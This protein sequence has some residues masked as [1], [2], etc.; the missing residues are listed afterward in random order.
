[1]AV[2][3]TEISPEV[4][5]EIAGLAGHQLADPAVAADCQALLERHGVVVY[6]ETHVGDDDLVAFSRLLGQVVVAPVG[7][8]DTHPE[9]SKITLDPAESVLAAYRRGTFFWHIDGANDE[10]PQKATL[11]TAR[12][13]S[14]EGGDTE[15]A[16]T[17]AAYEALSDA[18]KE[19]FAKLR[20][21]HSFA[22][23]Q[24]LAE[25][26]ASERTRA[27]WARVP[28]REHPLVWTRR[29]GRR[30]L[31]VGAT[32]D[33]VVGWP[34]DESRALLDRL[35]EWSTQPR[36]VLR[37]HWHPGD[38]VIWDNT[39]MLH[40]AIPYTATSHRLMHRTTLVGEEV[41]A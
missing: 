27:L 40:R 23:S 25:P 18:E 5:V 6:R 8:T 4:G 35:L 13:V 38:L 36:F 10:L 16:N 39:G 28:A 33:H 34:A 26:D 30:S 17:Y 7:G 37:H 3:V 15:F 1:M 24:S 11:L 2:T 22:A 31:L 12:Q 20:V 14:D 19:Q 32:T 21:V 29:S 41:V 9:I